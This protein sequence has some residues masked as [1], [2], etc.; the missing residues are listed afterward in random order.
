MAA[1]ISV[2]KAGGYVAIAEAELKIKFFGEYIDASILRLKAGGAYVTSGTIPVNTV[3]PT[4]AGDAALGATLTC[5][6]G[7]W[8]GNPTP[9]ITHHWEADGI[10]IPGE[11]GLTYVTQPEDAGKLIRCVERATNSLASLVMPTNA[12]LMPDTGFSSGFDS[13]FH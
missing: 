4:L 7:T 13:G 3:A 5:T 11:T 10:D 9:V 12:I 6:P 1:V 2:K 8:T